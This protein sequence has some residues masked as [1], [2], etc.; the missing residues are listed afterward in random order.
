[1]RQEWP[2]LLWVGGIWLI[3]LQHFGSNSRLKSLEFFFWLSHLSKSRIFMDFSCNVFKKFQFEGLGFWEKVD[4]SLVGIMTGM[5]NA[6]ESTTALFVFPR[7]Q[8]GHLPL[9]LDVMSL[10]LLCVVSIY[11]RTVCECQVR[12]YNTRLLNLRGIS[13]SSSSA[14]LVRSRANWSLNWPWAFTNPTA[15]WARKA[16]RL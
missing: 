13:S 16:Q 6:D 10:L 9:V 5:M 2:S 11:P 7:W 15:N 4:M 3:P 8:E 14:K 1:M 12:Y